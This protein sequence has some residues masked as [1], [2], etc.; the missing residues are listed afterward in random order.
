MILPKNNCSLCSRLRSFREN[1]NK[2]NPQWFNKPVPNFGSKK[3]QLLIVGLAPGLKGA[4]KTGR[5]FTGDYAGEVLYK[6]LLNNNFAKGYYDKNSKDNLKL[7]N[8]IITN[9]VKCVP[10]K[11]KPTTNEIYTCNKFLKSEIFNLKKIK[12]ILVLGR[13]AH[14]AILKVFK[15]KNSKYTFG[16]KKIH[17]INDYIIINS[18]H[19]SKYNIFTK[20]LSINDFNSIIKKAKNYL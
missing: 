11:N 17:K 19:C 18:Y 16:H 6:A 20:R 15:L 13:V 4:N 14:I 8:C 2:I 9:A 12:V 5:P 7:N 3:S 10:P 1:N